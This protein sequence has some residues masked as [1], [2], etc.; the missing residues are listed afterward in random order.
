M[1]SWNGLAEHVHLAAMVLWTLLLL[2]FFLSFP[3]P[4]RVAQAHLSTVVIYAPWAILLGCLV[5]ELIFHP[6]FYHTFGSYT[7][8][9]LL[10]YVVLGVVALIHSWAKMPREEVR[11]TGLGMV[12]AGVAIGVGGILLWAVD[13]ILLQGFDIPGTNWAPVLFGV[14]PIGMVLGVRKAA[15]RE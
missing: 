15:L 2:R 13:A 8:L 7:G 9:L 3:K 12:L 14:I 1:G 4:K 10:I 11:S 5:V 6:R